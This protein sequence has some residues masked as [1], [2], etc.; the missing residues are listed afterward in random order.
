MMQANSAPI[1]RIFS[2]GIY[3][4]EEL[5]Q[6]LQSVSEE[7]LTDMEELFGL[8]R[9]SN[10]PVEYL[11]EHILDALRNRAMGRIVERTQSPITRDELRKIRKERKKKKS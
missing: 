9:I 3:N 11:G 7:A 6:A 5:L 1:R 4:K 10:S 2:D 8:K